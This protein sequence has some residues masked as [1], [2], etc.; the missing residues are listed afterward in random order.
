MATDP[1]PKIA[2]GCSGALVFLC[3]LA[4]SAAAIAPIATDGRAS[5]NESMPFI[6]SGGVC[7]ALSGFLMV[8]AIIWLVVASRSGS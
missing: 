4:T 7:C 1:K 5:W 3:I 2:L 8:G 6:V